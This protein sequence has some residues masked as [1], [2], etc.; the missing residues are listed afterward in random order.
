METV[1]RSERFRRDLVMAGR[2][3]QDSFGRK[4]VFLSLRHTFGTNLAR[5]GVAS[6]VAMALMR[7][8]DRRLADKV[9]T[10]ESLLGT[11]S[12]IDA[13]PS[14]GVGDSLIASQI[15][16]ARG[17][18]V[19]LAVARS[20]GVESKKNIEKIGENLVLTQVDAV[21]QNY[22]NGGSGGARTRNLC[23]DRAAL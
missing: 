5:G 2:A 18:G 6:R 17:Q 16:G 4:A 21:G 19:S 7:Q 13:L 3:P 9:Y 1:P 20:G 22:E 10:D 12:A 11:A 23:R 14:Y 15:L 8:S